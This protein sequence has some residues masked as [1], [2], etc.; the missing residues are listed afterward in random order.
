MSSSFSTSYKHRFFCSVLIKSTVIPNVAIS[1]IFSFQHF[2][3]NSFICDLVIRFILRSI[4]A[5]VMQGMVMCQHDMEMPF[6]KDKI[7]VVSNCRK[8]IFHRWIV[9]NKQA[10]NIC[11]GHNCT[12]NVCFSLTTITQHQVIKKTT[13]AI[14]VLPSTSCSKNSTSML[15]MDKSNDGKAR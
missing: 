14:V 1:L 4:N 3:W 12:A 7:L 15:Y 2:F 8:H 5:Y 11:Y 6:K 10:N 13:V 9:P